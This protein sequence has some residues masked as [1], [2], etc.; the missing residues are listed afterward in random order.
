MGTMDSS[1]A[2]VEGWNA[3]EDW[4]IGPEVMKLGKFEHGGDLWK[5]V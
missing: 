4:W 3:G 1:A 2:E 5:P